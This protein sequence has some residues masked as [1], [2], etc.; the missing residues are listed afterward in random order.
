MIELEEKVSKEQRAV[1][2]QEPIIE[3]VVNIPPPPRRSSRVSHPPERYMGMLI[4]DVGEI[5]L[6]RD[7]GHGNDLN[8]FDEVISDDAMKSEIDSMDSNKVWIL[9][10]PSEGIESIR[11]K[12]IY[13]KKYMQ[14]VR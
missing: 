4:K 13:K 10:D 6:M 9:V 11:C 2:P 3:L 14:M 8:T 7:K 1:D 12:W 5:F